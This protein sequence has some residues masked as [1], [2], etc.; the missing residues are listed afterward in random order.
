[1]DHATDQRYFVRL[2]GE[3]CYLS[4]MSEEDAQQYAAWLND[5]EI[6]RNL[7]VAVQ[8][9][10]VTS[11]RESLRA[12]AGDHSYSVVTRNGD[13]IIGNVGLLDITILSVRVRSGSSSGRKISGDRGTDARRWHFSCATPLTVSTCATSGGGRM[14]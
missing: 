14:P 11:E 7:T 6:A 8:N 9:I 12:H 10:A 4:P 2:V 1:M 5:L 13:R 3:P